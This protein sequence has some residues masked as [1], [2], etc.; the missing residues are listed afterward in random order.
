VH[1]QSAFRVLRPPRQRMRRCVE[2]VKVGDGDGLAAAGDPGAEVERGGGAGIAWTTILT[3]PAKLSPLGED[4][5]SVE[6]VRWPWR[7]GH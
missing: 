5:D 6:L 4:I 2:P 1:G 7:S 3:R